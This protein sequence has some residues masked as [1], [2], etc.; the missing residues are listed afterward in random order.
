MG[1]A[2]DKY[3]VN[4]FWEATV[5]F[6][7]GTK[8]YIWEEPILLWQYPIQ[9]VITLKNWMIITISYVDNKKS[10]YLFIWHKYLDNIKPR[11][12]IS[13]EHRFTN[14]DNI[15]WTLTTIFNLK[16]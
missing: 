3:V 14:V 11:N 16:E 13:F 1:V 4:R 15:F 6:K 8:V 7:V 12:S 5:V 2:I 10:M 9:E